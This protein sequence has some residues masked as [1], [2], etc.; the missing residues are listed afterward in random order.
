LGSQENLAFRAGNLSEKPI[1]ETKGFRIAA[2]FLRLAFRQGW[3][4]KWQT[5]N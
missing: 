5:L 3:N 4:E 2:T 1:S